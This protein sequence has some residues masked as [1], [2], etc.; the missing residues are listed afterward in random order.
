MKSFEWAIEDIV[1]AY[2]SLEFGDYA[3]MAVALMRHAAPPCSF[4]VTMDGFRIEEIEDNREF[5][6]RV[7]WNSTTGAAAQR[8]ERTRQRTQ[9]VEGGAIGIAFLLFAHLIR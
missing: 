2:P 1:T 9:L 8:L 5:D 4:R 7:T 6:L 3:A